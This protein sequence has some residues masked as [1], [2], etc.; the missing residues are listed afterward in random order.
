[1]HMRRLFLTLMLSGMGLVATSQTNSKANANQI[2]A[3][4]YP[5][6]MD[7]VTKLISYQGVVEVSG[8]KANELYKRISDWFHTY[9]KNP[10]EVIRQDDSVE[11]VMMGKPRFRLMIQ[12][13]K[14]GPM[15]EGNSTVQYTITVAAR[16]GRFRYEL[17]TFNWKQLSYYPCEKWMDT[18]SSAYQP[19]FDEYLKQLEQYATTTVKSLKDVVT[20]AKSIKDKDNW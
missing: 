4:P 11:N 9:Y 16:D 13:E 12:K 2:P 10:T 6:Q 17:T 20:R 1:M 14:E 5:V 3:A 19:V 8:V 18:K 15:V 7:T